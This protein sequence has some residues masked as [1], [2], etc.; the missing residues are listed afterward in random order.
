[1]SLSRSEVRTLG[2]GGT[3][4]TRRAGPLLT[5]PVVAGLVRA[6]DLL[7]VVAAGFVAG[8]LRFGVGESEAPDVL[9]L[10]HLS[11]S[12]V[13]ALAFGSAAGYAFED[14]RDPGRALGRLL[15]A[16][17]A[18]IGTV[19]VVLDAL[20][21]GEDVS[22]LWVGYWWGA[23]ALALMGFRIAVGLAIGT[24]QRHGALRRAVLVVGGP[25]GAPDGRLA[26]RL[27]GE[28]GEEIR[29][30]GETPFPTG[31]AGPPNGH[32]LRRYPELAALLR[33]RH[34][35]EV[36]IA[37]DGVAAE[38]VAALVRWLRTFPVAASLATEAIGGRLPVLGLARI[39]RT[40]LL[41]V[42][43]RPLDG[44]QRVVKTLEDRIL[45]SLFL[46]LAAPLMAV[47]AVTVK[48]TSPGPVLYRQLRHGFNQQPIEVL[49]FR[50]M[51]A[52]CCD[53][54]DAREVRQATRD[55]PRVTPVGRFLR[56]TSLD[57]LP[58]LINVVRGEMSLVGP[59][60]HALAHNDAY[61]AMID[62]YLARHRV[63]PGITGWAQVNGCRGETA[64][65][66]EMERRIRFD[67]EY[68]ERWSLL[69][70]LLILARTV[71][72]LLDHRNAW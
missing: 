64:T 20:K 49:K 25:G 29:I 10:V 33:E 26:S 69:F 30:V 63:K 7:V 6:G 24:A 14:L 44:W 59:R 41:R 62:D 61:A 4:A 43:E 16:W 32:P 34:V 1:V 28:V 23:G 27:L 37:T 66:E 9:R 8:W 58:Q 42:V 11:G 35:D 53:P 68:V 12:L 67:L 56:R 31:R 21:S 52:D 65:L 46:L 40:P 47:I 38:D 45:G 15:L 17:S 22:R 51:Y 48:L 60:P 50:T 54:P 70:D 71:H 2:G 55:D 5:R 3:G 72:R 57:E 18:A 19:L 39:G 13:A 36:V